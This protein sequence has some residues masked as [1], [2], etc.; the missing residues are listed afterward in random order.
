MQVQIWCIHIFKL[1]RTKK[2]IEKFIEKMSEN[3]AGHTRQI[4][5]KKDVK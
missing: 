4:N 2:I 1:S 5:E 3:N